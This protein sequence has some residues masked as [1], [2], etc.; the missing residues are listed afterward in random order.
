MGKS[1]LSNKLC[2]SVVNKEITD[3]LGAIHP[4]MTDQIYLFYCAVVKSNINNEIGEYSHLVLV[5]I[6][7]KI[8]FD[9]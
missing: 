5:A 2:H 9:K 3:S 8:S 1:S 4:K 6:N 7:K